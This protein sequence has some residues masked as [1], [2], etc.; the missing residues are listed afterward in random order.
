[1][2]ARVIK[3]RHDENTRAKIK[4]AHI[5]YEL[6]RHFNGERDL[7]QTQLKAAEILLRK[8]M[9]DLQSVEVSG[10]ITT[11]KVI[12]APEQSK[13]AKTW[14]EQHVPPAYTEH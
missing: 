6:H 10:E 14:S 5:L 1:M 3:I 11:S 4:V 2:P 9:P 12:R 7:S 13:D 8:A